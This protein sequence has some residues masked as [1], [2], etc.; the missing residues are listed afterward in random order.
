MNLNSTGSRLST[1][2]QALVSQGLAARSEETM[3]TQDK[4][5][6]SLQLLNQVAE[7]FSGS[8]EAKVAQAAVKSVQGI[9]S[10]RLVEAATNTALAMLEG[11]I[12]GA[13]GAA[14]CKLG[15]A[16]NNRATAVINSDEAV[17]ISKSLARDAVTAGCGAGLEVTQR[18]LESPDIHDRTKQVIATNGF[19]Y[20]GVSNLAERSPE[21]LRAFTALDAGISTRLLNH[22]DNRWGQANVNKESSAAYAI[23][24]GQEPGAPPS[25]ALEHQLKAKL[26][27]QL[28]QSPDAAGLL[29]R[30]RRNEDLFQK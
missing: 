27:A 28:E 21:A 15:H 13:A 12:T 6:D 20:A 5:L 25:E 9:Q 14:I 23:G 3:S 24:L 22:V 29:S 10:E 19:F 1:T 11:G 17:T 16:F 26:V 8:V 4:N 30:Y 18:L 7:S 2:P